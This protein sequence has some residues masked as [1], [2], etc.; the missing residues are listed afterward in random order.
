MPKQA[1]AAARNST[2]ATGVDYEERQRVAGLVLDLI[3][4]HAPELEATLRIEWSAR[5]TSRLGD[6][7]LVTPEGAANHARRARRTSRKPIEPVARLRF[8]IP[9]WPRATRDDRDATVAHEVAHLVTMQRHP[10]A[11]AHGRAWQSVMLE[12]GYT[13]NRTHSI[14][15]RGLR[16]RDRGSR[17]AFECRACAKV[18]RVSKR[19]AAD[20]ARGARRF[21]CRCHAPQVDRELARVFESVA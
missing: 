17:V 8:S 6:A 15:T 5:F 3:R 19:H 9:I 2:A 21:F 14:D 4:A 13:P 16:R 18:Y 10:G 12:M 11:A 20:H 1:T 7:M